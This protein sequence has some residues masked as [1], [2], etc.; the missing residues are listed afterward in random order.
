MLFGAW[1]SQME[2]LPVCEE[3]IESIYRRLAAMHERYRR[4]TDR[5]TELRQYRLI[6][7]P[8][9]SRQ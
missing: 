2:A 8:A 4:Q 3:I 9:M 1:R 6:G 5:Q 7:L